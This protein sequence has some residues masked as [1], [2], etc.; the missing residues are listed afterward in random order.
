MWVRV[1]AAAVGAAM[2]LSSAAQAA[3]YSIGK[4][5]DCAEAAAAGGM[6]RTD[7]GLCNEALSEEVLSRVER[8]GVLVNRGAIYMARKEM[9]LALADF[10]A[11]IVLVP[12]LSEAWINRGTVYRR[13]G[14]FAHSIADITKGLDLGAAEPA[15]AHYNRALAHEGMGDLK[16]AYLDYRQ[17]ATLAP[18]W[19]PPQTELKRFTVVTAAKK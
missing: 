19:G 5:R 1:G 12:E 14:D 3:T 4:A 17:A 6:G 16:S 18:D 11:A 2:I 7:I 10:D 15:K 8:A 9:D 13:K